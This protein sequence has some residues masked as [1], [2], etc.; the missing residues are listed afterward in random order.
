MEDGIQIHEMTGLLEDLTV[1]VVWRVRERLL[2]GKRAA[3][4]FDVER[5]NLKKLSDV[6]DKEEY[7]VKI[8]NRFVALENLDDMDMNRFWE[9]N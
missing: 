2:V 4:T 8:S 7:N 5:F 6:E 1:T 3:I 9:N